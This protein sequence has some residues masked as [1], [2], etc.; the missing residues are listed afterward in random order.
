VGHAFSARNLLADLSKS[1]ADTLWSTLRAL[2]ES[3][4]LM[5]HISDHLH[6][7]QDSQTADLFARKAQEARQRA[8]HVRQM[9]TQ[10]S[11]PSPEVISEDAP[12]PAEETQ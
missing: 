5:Q 11:A 8:E 1:R 9:V 3:I 12:G 2:E 6:A 4:M 10:L 7:E